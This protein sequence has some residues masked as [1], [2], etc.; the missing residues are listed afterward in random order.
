MT[1]PIKSLA[2]LKKADTEKPM[3]FYELKHLN[4]P[5][6]FAE[7]RKAI[8]HH[9][10]YWQVKR[11]KCLSIMAK[12]KSPTPEQWVQLAETSTALN[13]LGFFILWID[14]FEASVRERNFCGE[15]SPRGDAHAFYQKLKEKNLTEE[16]IQLLDMAL[17]MLYFT[18]LQTDV[19]C[20]V[21][22]IV[23]K[24]KELRGL[25]NGSFGEAPQKRGL[26]EGEK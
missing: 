5:T 18:E 1:E 26:L 25:L 20:K 19:Y 8:V 17:A 9:K 12:A 7:M 23:A 11:E 15:K 21:E 16:D 6:N 10:E 14:S 3:D 22:K 24:L 4:K 13:L 2:E